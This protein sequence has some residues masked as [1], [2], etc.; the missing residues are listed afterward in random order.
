MVLRLNR[1]KLLLAAGYGVAAAASYLGFRH[2]RARL[3]RETL[4]KNPGLYVL[5]TYL[6][7]ESGVLRKN[8]ERRAKDAQAAPA[9]PSQDLKALKERMERQSNTLATKDIMRKLDKTLVPNLLLIWADEARRFRRETRSQ[10]FPYVY[11]GMPHNVLQA[12]GFAGGDVEALLRDGKLNH[13]ALSLI[14]SELENWDR[15]DWIRIIFHPVSE[16]ERTL[17]EIDRD[18]L[19]PVR[20]KRSGPKQSGSLPEEG[21]QT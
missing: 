6:I 16:D 9:A 7:A 19:L 12:Y 15:P 8:L 10:G 1:R 4:L 2:G 13:R 11:H 20:G 14:K 5:K 17:L 3:E 21:K 18:G